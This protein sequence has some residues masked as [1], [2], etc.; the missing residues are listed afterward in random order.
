M[1]CGTDDLT[2]MTEKLPQLIMRRPHLRDLPAARV[3]PGYHVRHFRPG[4][5]SGWNELMDRAFERRSGQSD[6]A[7]EMA[8]DAPYRP[9]RVKLVLDDAGTVVA[10]ASCWRSPRFGNDSMMLHWVGTDPSHSGKGLGTAVS[11][12][13]LQQGLSEERRRA[14][15]LTDDFRVPALKT[16]LRLAFVPVLTHDSHAGRWRDI[17][18]ELSWPERF[19]RIL[20]APLE[21]LPKG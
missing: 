13:A 2:S 8:A 15:L 4:D 18:D 20:T 12:E 21:S 5:E 1:A 10:T 16:Y 19:E 7:R 9:E 14:W 11:V 17:L 6:F 3:P